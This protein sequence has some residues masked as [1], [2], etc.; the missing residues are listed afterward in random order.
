MVECHK[1]YIYILKLDIEL[2][3]V[4]SSFPRPDVAQKIFIFWSRAR[5]AKIFFQ[6]NFW[7]KAWDPD[8]R[9]QRLKLGG[10]TD[11]FVK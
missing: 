7:M 3:K 9:D 2:Y 1:L 4:L 8:I 10:A 11:F 6:K 5:Q